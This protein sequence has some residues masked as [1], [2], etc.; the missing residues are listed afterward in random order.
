MPRLVVPILSSAGVPRF[1]M[2]V[3]FAVQRQDERDVLGDFEVG[4]R[5]LDPL[6]AQL[7]DFLDEMIGIEDDAV[8]DDRQLPGAHDAGR[9]QREFVSFAVDHQRMAGVMAALKADDD[10]GPD[11]KPIDDLALSF[12]APLGADNDNVGHR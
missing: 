6:A 8:A 2:G 10:V 5:H 3:E 11:R 9:K 7:L 1:A 4:R 12:V